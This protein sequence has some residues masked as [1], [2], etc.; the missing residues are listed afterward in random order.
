MIENVYF[1]YLGKVAKNEVIIGVY[2]IHAHQAE[3]VETRSPHAVDTTKLTTTIESLDKSAPLLD[4][5]IKFYAW[6]GRGHGWAR[7][8]RDSANQLVPHWFSSD[9]VYTC[10]PKNQLFGWINFLDIEVNESDVS[11]VNGE[12]VGTGSDENAG[13]N[14]NQITRNLVITRQPLFKAS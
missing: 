12:L 6:L 2:S 3:N 8:T 11:V 10:E 13:F 9:V 5:W 4:D 7:F 14:F 1:V